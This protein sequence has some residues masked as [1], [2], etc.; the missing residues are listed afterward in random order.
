MASQCDLSLPEDD[1][2]QEM[3]SVRRTQCYAPVYILP[4]IR[5]VNGLWISTAI[6]T[7]DKH[8]NNDNPFQME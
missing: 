7:N 6:R 8:G 2:D 4:P 5:I 3:G 1:S